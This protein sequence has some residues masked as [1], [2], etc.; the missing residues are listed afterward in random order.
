MIRYGLARYLGSWR[1]ASGYSL[2]IRRA[3]A[4]EARVDFLTPAGVPVCRPY[5]ADAPSVDMIA[6]YNDYE[7][8]LD[9][10]LWKAGRGFTLVLSHEYDYILDDQQRESLV[11]GISRNMV[12]KFLDAYYP[13]FGQLEHFVRDKR[14]T[15][16]KPARS[17]NKMIS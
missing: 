2:R 10:D 7:G 15:P 5:M 13:L 4:Q 16:I 17:T 3:R 8:S 1:T 9:V 11:A 14:R 12:D 6:R